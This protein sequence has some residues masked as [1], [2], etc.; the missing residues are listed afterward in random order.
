[1]HAYG[2][3]RKLG[4]KK[5]ICPLGAGVTSAIGLLGAP[6][7]ADLS[8]SLPM[9][10]PRW[11]AQVVQGVLESLAAQ[12]REVVLASGVHSDDIGFSYTV[13]MRHVGQGH[14]ISVA[15]PEVGKFGSP[16]EP[17]FLDELLK[18]FHNAYIKLYGRNVSGT[19]AEV[20]TWRVRASGPKGHVTANGLRGEIKAGRKPRKGSRPVFFAEAGG[21]VD[22]SVYDHYAL[23]PGVVVQGPAIIEQRESTT[24]VGP[25]A[26]ASLDDQYNLI[27]R[28]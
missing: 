18:R 3:A 6:V 19:D 22:T 23:A 15:L 25:K 1:V 7:A 14:E 12:G 5:L 28:L 17:A 20:I 10:I 16:A 27:M 11:D 8:T 24:V 2:V 21:V 13:D 4:I 26:S 9:A